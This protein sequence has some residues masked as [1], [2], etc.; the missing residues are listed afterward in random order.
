MKI[1]SAVLNWLHTEGGWS[2]MTKLTGAFFKFAMQA[3]D[4]II[5]TISEKIKV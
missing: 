2:E 4:R 1:R 5:V 3:N